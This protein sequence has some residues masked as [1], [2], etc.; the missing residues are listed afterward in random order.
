MADTGTIVRS[1]STPVV[2][3]MLG[4]VP[5]YDVPTIPT[6]PVLQSAVTGCPSSSHAFARP[7]SQ[8]MIA[9]VA[10]VSFMSPIVGQPSEKAVPMLSP[11]TTA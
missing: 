2:A 9:L 8:S 11:S 6:S 4:S 10:S 5:L 7:F 3:T 1:P